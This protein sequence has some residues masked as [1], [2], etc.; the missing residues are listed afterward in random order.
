MFQK[1]ALSELFK[2]PSA[3]PRQDVRASVSTYR[4][5]LAIV[6]DPSDLDVIAAPYQFTLV[7]KFSRGKPSMEELQ[8]IFLLLDLKKLANLGL[9]DN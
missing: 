7:G 3:A 4:G 9:L 5:D 2:A 1:K 6:F 8:K